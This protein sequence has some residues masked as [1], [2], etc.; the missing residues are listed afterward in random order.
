MEARYQFTYTLSQELKFF[1]GRRILLRVCKQK[2]DIALARRCISIYALRNEMSPA[3]LSKIANGGEV[4]AKTV[5]R[6]AR[7]L[8]CDPAELIDTVGGSQQ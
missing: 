2:L 7:L 5:G 6:L 8:D 3:T 1:K 4:R